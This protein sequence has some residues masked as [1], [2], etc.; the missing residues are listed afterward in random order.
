MYKHILIATDGSEL[1]ERG[2]D[3]GLGLAKALGAAVTLVTVTD[4]WS[5]LAMANEALRGHPHPAEQFESEMAAA[6]GRVLRAAQGK[7]EALGVTAATIHVADKHPA[8]GVIDTAM[9]GGCDLI[10]MS[11]HGRRGAK[12][13]MLGSQTAEVVTHTTIPVLVIR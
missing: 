11:S 8:Q 3:H 1:A 6:A 12:R 5:P 4:F 2:L 9:E 13:L 7:A 10:V